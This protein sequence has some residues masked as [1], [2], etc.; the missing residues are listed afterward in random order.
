MSRKLFDIWSD[1]KFNLQFLRCLLHCWGRDVFGCE[2]C[3][4]VYDLDGKWAGGKGPFRWE[5]K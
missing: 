5:E 3:F 2:F 4:P 1:I